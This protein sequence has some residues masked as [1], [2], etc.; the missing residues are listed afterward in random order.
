MLFVSMTSAGYEVQPGETLAGIAADHGT[1]VAALVEANGI[2]DP[3]LIVAGQVLTIPGE[4][5]ETS[6][7]V[8]PG[9]TLAGIAASYG[10]T[11]TDLIDANGLS[12]PD[13]LW[14]GQLIS[15]PGG[16]D[17]ST[18]PEQTIV[19]SH[20]VAAGE[21]LASIARRYGTTVEAI[22]QVNGI[23]NPSQIFVGTQLTIAEGLATPAPS[24]PMGT[25][26]H[27]VEAGETLAAIASRFGTSVQALIATNGIEN[28]DLIK[29][30]QQLSVPASGW[31]CP[32]VGSRYFNDW[33]FPRSGGRFHQGNDLFA[34]RGT[35]VRSPV[36]GFVELKSGVVGGLQF[37]MTGDDGRTYIGT[38][39]EGF[40]LAGDVQAG[41]VIGYVGD[42][43]N[44]VGSDP[45]LHFEILVDGSPIN[46]YPVLRENGC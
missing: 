3:D 37:W 9:E 41:A 5:G 6:H 40:A 21:T 33:G 7:T 8:G 12:N 38:H 27:T 2:T 16:Q 42:S 13:L 36:S 46:P 25:S 32:V 18:G 45:H 35:E 1:T 20:L 10:V 14:I 22:A 28:P 44:A 4:S 30:G 39:L 31:I 11:V 15:I 26:L 19:G 17:S 29:A 34:Q 24:E 23:T 43:G